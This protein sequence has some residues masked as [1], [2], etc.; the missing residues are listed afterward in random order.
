M[1]IQDNRRLNVH[2]HEVNHIP[3]NNG[4]DISM[5]VVYIYQYNFK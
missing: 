3:L 2:G 5:T 4:K 1:E